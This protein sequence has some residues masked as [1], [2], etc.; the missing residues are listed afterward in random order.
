MIILVVGYA[1]AF[2]VGSRYTEDNPLELN[3]GGFIEIKFNF[4][5][6]QG[7]D[8]TFRPNIVE[9]SGVITFIN[10]EDVFLR[11]GDSVNVRANVVVPADAEVGD[12]YPIK[13]TFTTVSAGEGGTLG[14]GS[15]VG[16]NFDLIIVPTAEELALLAPEGEEIAKGYGSKWVIIGVVILILVIVFL[17]LMMKKKKTGNIKK[18]SDIKKKK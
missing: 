9:S 1:S 5:N 7:N 8:L 13:L 10:T 18:V 4:Q 2:G 11:V 15:S 16:R 6:P 14:L 12:V 17:F 3:K